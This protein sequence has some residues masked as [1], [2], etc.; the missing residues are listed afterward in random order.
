M[1]RRGLMWLGVVWSVVLGGC[2]SPLSGSENVR[3]PRND[4]QVQNA[5]LAGTK[6]GTTD[7]DGIPDLSVIARN[8]AVRHKADT[9]VLTVQPRTFQKFEYTI[10]A[11]RST[12]KP[13]GQ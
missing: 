11:W 4:S 1:N 7:R 13:A 9:V 5:E 12:P 6:T 8:Y 3:L 10:Q 2:L